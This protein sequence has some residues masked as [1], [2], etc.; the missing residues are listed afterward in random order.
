MLHQKNPKSKGYLYFIPMIYICAG[1]HTLGSSFLSLGCTLSMFHYMC[2]R[3]FYI[4]ACVVA[5]MR[6]LHS[7]SDVLQDSD[8]IRHIFTI[9]LLFLL[10][11]FYSGGYHTKCCEY[12]STLDFTR[13]NENDE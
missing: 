12:D 2:W 9:N 1:L 8:T 11:K 3:E 5:C 13:G 10:T 4:I 7:I 6:I